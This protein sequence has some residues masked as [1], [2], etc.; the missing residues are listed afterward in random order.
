MP[1]YREFY[2]YEADTYAIDAG[3]EAAWVHRRT[4]VHRLL[5]IEWEH[6]G[7][8]AHVTDIAV[9]DDRHVELPRQQQ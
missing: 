5:E 7:R 1:T 3:H 4:L 6:P 9:L 2:E 8:A